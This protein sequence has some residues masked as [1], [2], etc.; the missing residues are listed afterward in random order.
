MTS[1]EAKNTAIALLKDEANELACMAHHDVWNGLTH[2]ARV[3]IQNEIQRLR[4]AA[5]AMSEGESELAEVKSD[6]AEHLEQIENLGKFVGYPGCTTAMIVSETVSL[7]EKLR[8]KDHVNARLSE[9]LHRIANTDIIKLDADTREEYE[10]EF[11]P[12]AQKLA[13]EALGQN[14]QGDGQRPTP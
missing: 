8:A 1:I 14:D 13:R 12:W 5:E 7:I 2:R 6:L 10:R 4:A 3:A 9:A 11:L